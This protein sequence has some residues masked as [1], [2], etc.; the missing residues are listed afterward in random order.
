[1]NRLVIVTSWVFGLMLLALSLFV[2]VETISRKLWNFSFQGADELGGY[3]LAVGGALSFT[4]ALVERG[5]IRIDLIHEHLPSVLQALLNWLSILLLAGLGLFF[6]WYGFKVIQ[7][8]LAY[9]SAAATPWATPLIYPQTVWY[10]ALALFALTAS[11]LAIRAT[12]LLAQ[13]QRTALN[14]DFHPRGAME[15][16][17]EEISDLERR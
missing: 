12:L 9:R 11:I 6:A 14:A 15:E 4:I 2:T 5:H 16:L 7:D 10:I 3:V 8:T 17:A 13:G 1:M